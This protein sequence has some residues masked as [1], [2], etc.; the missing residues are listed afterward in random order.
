MDTLPEHIQFKILGYLPP[1]LLLNLK[2]PNKLYWLIYR[3]IK[4]EIKWDDLIDWKY[5]FFP[6]HS[7]QVNDRLYVYT[8]SDLIEEKSCEFKIEANKIFT[9]Q[10]FQNR[11]YFIKTLNKTLNWKNWYTV[12][13]AVKNEYLSGNYYNGKIIK[14]CVYQ[15]QIEDLIKIILEAK[16]SH[17]WT[18]DV[19][20]IINNE[21]NLV[22]DEFNKFPMLFIS[23]K[24]LRLDKISLRHRSET[25]Y[26]LIWNIYCQS[27]RVGTAILQPKF[28]KMYGNVPGLAEYKNSKGFTSALGQFNGKLLLNC[29]PKYLNY[30]NA[31]TPPILK[32]ISDSEDDNGR[33]PLIISES[34]E[35]SD[36]SDWS[37]DES[38]LWSLNDSDD[39]LYTSDDSDQFIF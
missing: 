22:L 20:K 36:S 23:N 9:F 26:L 31:H 3:E 35:C 16:K 13:H 25:R 37:F 28:Y 39:L 12:Y 38:D 17:S 15:T 24:C 4:S 27:D 8:L 1:E 21:T 19:V 14:P 11:G 32:D 10:T 6:L 7:F 29:F 5:E 30:K 33:N 2:L 34:S 18:N